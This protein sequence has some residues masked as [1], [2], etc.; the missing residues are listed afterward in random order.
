[1]N[2]NQRYALV[3][4]AVVVL[5]VGFLLA[6]GASDDGSDSTTQTA[7]VVRT[8]VET[9]AAGGGDTVRTVQTTET[10]AP[11]PAVATVVVRDG[12]PVGGV[13][14]LRFDKGGTID[15][16]VR[17]NAPGGEVHFHGYD[18]A[19]E[20]PADGGRVRFTT[21]AKFDGRFEV[22]MEATGTQIAEVEVQP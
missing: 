7:T 15:F 21:Q 5:V 9:T 11:K 13:E 4:L 3:G 17:A 20:I 12:Q 2:A 1:M 6:R 16:V 19:K 14:R 22:E 8:V 10:T 18:L